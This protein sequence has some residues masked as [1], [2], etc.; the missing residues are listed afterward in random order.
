[1][2]ADNL[3]ESDDALDLVNSFVELG[4]IVILIKFLER[5]E[6]KTAEDK[7]GVYKLLGIFESL[8]DVKPEI[9]VMLCPVDKK[10]DRKNEIDGEDAKES[11]VEPVDLGL[12]KWLFDRM[13]KETFD[14]NKAYCAELL[15]ILLAADEG[16]RRAMGHSKHMQRLV[17]LTV[18]YR[19]KNPAS[20][21]E[22]EYL[23][24][25]FNCLCHAMNDVPE[26]QAEF[27]EGKGLD[28]IIHVVKLKELKES[29]EKVVMKDGA[30]RLMDFALA[31]CPTNC[32]Y[33]VNAK[34]LSAIFSVFMG[35]TKFSKQTT[36][37]STNTEHTVSILVHLFLSVADV[38]YYRLLRKFQENQYEKVERLVELFD[39]YFSRLEEVDRLFATQNANATSED[40]LLERYSRRCDA[41]LLT[42]RYLCFVM[43]F[44]ATCGDARLLARLRQLLSLRDNSFS[45]VKKVLVEYFSDMDEA[46]SAKK[47][48]LE[49]IVETM[50]E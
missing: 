50:P 39:Q 29:K 6:E 20:D 28:V 9:T 26:N 48:V 40:E 14:D 38:R 1:L 22:R 16:M 11:K 49:G 19:K 42:L 41:G 43:G 46:D 47:V 3:G 44:L 12:V 32:E 35:K 36:N 23:A 8:V 45:Q 37:E 25:L 33:F 21:E 7:E 30:L 2:D 4:G 24:N 13:K 5:Q 27:R 18:V 10:K 17:T 15:S 34:G 31:K